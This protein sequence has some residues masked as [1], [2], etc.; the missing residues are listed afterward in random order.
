MKTDI[1]LDENAFCL[2][3]NLDRYHYLQKCFTA[4]G[5][6]YPQL[7]PGVIH[8]TAG[9]K[10]C[11]LGHQG[12]MM[13]GRCLNLPYMV[14]YEDDAYP[15]PDVI[16]KFNEIMD[17]LENINWQVLVLG[18]NG[19]FSGFDGKSEDFWRLYKTAEER[20]SLKSIAQDVTLRTI[21]IPRNPNGSHAYIIKRQAYNEWL[22]ILTSHQFV[23]I[24]LGSLNW[25]KNRIL[26][27]KELLFVQKQIDKKC[28]TKLKVDFD[29]SY[30]YP[31]TYNKNY[32]G[33]TTI[34]KDPPAG[35]VRELVK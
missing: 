14:I 32:R 12:L 30:I 1:K 31:Y 19:E 17:E 20:N 5:L 29:V 28:M 22:N 3:C 21:D 33:C 8:P 16:S 6:R 2:S 9:Y 35:F 15:R 10:G 4:V 13:M 34:F 26:W 25:K 23:D 11:T 7:F 24:S 18:R 27:T